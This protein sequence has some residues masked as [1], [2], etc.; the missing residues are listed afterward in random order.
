MLHGEVS[1]G[2]GEDVFIGNSGGA[3]IVDGGAGKDVIV[4]GAG[5]D[6]LVGGRGKDRLF[7]G[8]GDDTIVGCYGKDV[9]EGGDGAD[10]FVFANLKAPDRIKDFAIGEDRIHL[11]NAAM[12][13]LGSDG[14]LAEDAFQV[15]PH[16]TD[17]EHRIIYDEETGDLWYDKNGSDD[18]GVTKLAKLAPGLDLTHHHF[19]II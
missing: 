17:D 5:A 16:A 13:A 18:G 8:E 11:D 4:G 7:G 14:A 6:H 12:K 1:L 15:G 2:A 10:T 9:L 19:E 3:L